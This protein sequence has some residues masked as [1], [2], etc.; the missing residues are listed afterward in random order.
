ME[1]GKTP[2]DEKRSP[3]FIFEQRDPYPRSPTPIECIYHRGS[4]Q[5]GEGRFVV[6]GLFVN[7]KTARN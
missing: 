4:K 1:N 6:Y 7:G 5:R 2:G 3:R